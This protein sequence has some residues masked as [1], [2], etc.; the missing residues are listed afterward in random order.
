MRGKRGGIRAAARL[1]I[2][3]VA[4]L[5]IAGGDGRAQQPAAPPAAVSGPPI[6][7]F[8]RIDAGFHTEVVNR[9]AVDAGGRIAATASDDK[10]VRLWSIADGSALGTLRVPIGEQEEGAIYAVALSPDGGTLLAGGHTGYAWDGSFAVYVFD[11]A[12]QRLRGRLPGLPAPINHL[13]Y[14]PDGKHFAVALGGRAGIR[15]H[16]AATGRL[17]FAD[18]DFQDRA[19]MVVFD[20]AGRLAAVGF[21]GRLRLYAPDGRKLGQ[22]SF[23]GGKPYG[24]AFSDDGRS[25][26]V[27][28]LD[29]PRVEIVAG[30]PDLK[31]VRT[32]RVA[33]AAGGLGAVAW[34]ADG[35]VIAGGAL[36]DR[37]GA[38]ILRMWTAAGR[39]QPVDL[40]LLRD[41]ISDLR[42]LPDGGM[43]IAGAD[44]A[45]VRIDRGGQK[46]FAHGGTTLDFREIGERR[47]AL[48]A[49]GTVVDMQPRNAG[50]ALRLDIA[51]RTIGPAE[52]PLDGEDA[53]AGA[54]PPLTDW[55][56][57]TD[58]KLGGRP[59]A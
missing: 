47:F 3:A 55:R 19:T 43:L 25:I 44:P 45:L 20:R 31:P 58:P 22:R 12:G 16:D 15:V 52:G 27:G 38:T 5:L 35:Q 48:S 49:D 46:V 53:P 41:T 39:G 59:L 2:A 54:R 34:G 33:N 8:L 7:P 40:P 23:Q 28:F 56:N 21:D 57:R 51:N 36:R 29:Q 10:T 37:S 42:M 6:R 4:L 1:A 32:L 17:V 11:L 30:S 50:G 18:A 13:A 26:A 14:S 24:L 9:I